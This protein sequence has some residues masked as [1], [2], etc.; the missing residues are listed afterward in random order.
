[1]P[2]NYVMQPT[3]CAVGQQV[4]VHAALAPAAADGERYTLLE[5]CK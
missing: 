2:P 5:P 3:T 4:K 1:M